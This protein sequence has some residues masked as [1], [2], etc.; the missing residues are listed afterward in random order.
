M[1]IKEGKRGI[2]ITIPDHFHK[3]IKKVAEGQ[4]LT[5][6]QYLVKSGTEGYIQSGVG[7]DGVLSNKKIRLSF[8]R[9]ELKDH[10][11]LIE[12]ISS[13]LKNIYAKS[14]REDWENVNE[15]VVKLL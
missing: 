13:K 3:I 8:K 9:E 6:S 4:N 7:I 1:T 14:T 15:I 2:L 5:V 11:I 12:N 10:Y